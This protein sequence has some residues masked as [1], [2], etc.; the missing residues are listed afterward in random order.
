MD[1]LSYRLDSAGEKKK[2]IKYMGEIT[3]NKIER[4]R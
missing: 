3:Q 2:T 4:N 1:R